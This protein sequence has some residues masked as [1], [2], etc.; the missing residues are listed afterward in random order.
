MFI[1]HLNNTKNRSISQF[2]LAAR[3]LKYNI[4]TLCV[5]PMTYV[6]QLYS[7]FFI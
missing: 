2:I 6:D 4:S 3:Q 5:Q 1:W 7:D